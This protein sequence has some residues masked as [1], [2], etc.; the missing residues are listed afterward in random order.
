MPDK[1]IP[2]YPTRSFAR[3][4]HYTRRQVR[5]NTSHPIMNENRLPYLFGQHDK[6]PL[7]KEERKE[8]AAAV[9][10]T[11]EEGLGLLMKDACEGLEGN[12]LFFNPSIGRQLLHNFL[13]TEKGKAQVHRLFWVKM[14][15]AAVVRL[16]ATGAYFMLLKKEAS[17][18]IIATANRYTSAGRY[19]SHYHPARWQKVALDNIRNGTLAIVMGRFGKNLQEITF[20]V[21][22]HR[23]A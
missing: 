1:K 21:P 14:A 16:L 17:P 2:K 5:L 6:E 19:K 15:A 13:I 23:N 4:R 18:D 10:E 9:Q 8:L 12:R 7:S 20:I 3:L 11:S 22:V